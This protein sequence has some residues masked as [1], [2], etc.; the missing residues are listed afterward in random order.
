MNKEASIN[1]LHEKKALI[2]DDH[3]NIRSSLRIILESKGAHDSGHFYR[4]YNDIVVL[5]LG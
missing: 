3:K 4:K 2:I 1:I 5:L